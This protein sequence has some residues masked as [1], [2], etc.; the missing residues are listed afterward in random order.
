MASCLTKYC[1]CIV[2]LNICNELTWQT[3]SIPLLTGTCKSLEYKVPKLISYKA[4]LEPRLSDFWFSQNSPIIH[5][6]YSFIFSQ[7]HCLHSSFLIAEPYRH[8]LHRRCLLHICP[9]KSL[10]WAICSGYGSCYLNKP[11]P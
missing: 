1:H 8:C 4:G 7:Y 11:K 3:L 2:S 6:G 5:T 10:Y 9:I